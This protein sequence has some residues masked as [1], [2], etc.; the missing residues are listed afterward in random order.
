MKAMNHDLP[1]SALSIFCGA[2][3]TVGNYVLQHAPTTTGFT[4][5]IKVVSLGLIGGAC[6]YL[7]RFIANKIHR[8][9]KSNVPDLCE[10][11]EKIKKQ[12]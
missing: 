9:F 6:G 11:D 10:Q 7:G 4:E 12:E 1:T 8:F 5:Y 2:L 3:L